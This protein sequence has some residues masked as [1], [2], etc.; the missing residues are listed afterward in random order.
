MPFASRPC[1]ASFS[2]RLAERHE[3]S[4]TCGLEMPSGAPEAWPQVAQAA[5]VAM[6]QQPQ[7]HA[8]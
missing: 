6:S 2:D 3:P 4:R 8:C 5:P 1:V 7:V